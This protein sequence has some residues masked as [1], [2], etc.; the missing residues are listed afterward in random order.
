MEQSRSGEANLFLASQ[1]ISYNL[2]KSKGSLPYLQVR[3][4]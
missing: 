4:T 3:A 2:W 1:E